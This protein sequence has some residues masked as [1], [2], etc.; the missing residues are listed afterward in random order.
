MVYCSSLNGTSGLHLCTC[1]QKGT[2]GT[3]KVSLRLQSVVPQDHAYPE[4]P[5]SRSLCCW[6]PLPVLSGEISGSGRKLLAAS[7]HGMCT[8]CACESHGARGEPMVLPGPAEAVFDPAHLP[9]TSTDPSEVP[10]PRLPLVWAL[11]FDSF[12]LGCI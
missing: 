4:K 7:C 11:L 9:A 3:S 8:A 10:E 1:Q 12:C 5:L 6:L 2:E